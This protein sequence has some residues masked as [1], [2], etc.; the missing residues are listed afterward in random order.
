MI[1][2]PRLKINTDE[3]SKEVGERRRNS[4][5]GSVSVWVL[6]GAT[7]DGPIPI[8]DVSPGSVNAYDI[9]VLIIAGSGG[10]GNVWPGKRV[11]QLRAFVYTTL[12]YLNFNFS[13]DIIWR[14]EM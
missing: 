3:L 13:E 10:N 14:F 5:I 4:V 7:I 6:R 12:T 9:T 2:A 8:I 11:T 1:E